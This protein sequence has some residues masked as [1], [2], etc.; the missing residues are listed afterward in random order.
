MNRKA[1]RPTGQSLNPDRL[2]TE[3]GRVSFWRN[4]LMLT[5]MITVDEAKQMVRDRLAYVITSGAIGAL[6]EFGYSNS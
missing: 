1:Y 4:G 5:A 3:T 6:D 2:Q